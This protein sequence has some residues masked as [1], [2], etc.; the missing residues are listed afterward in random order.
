MEEEETTPETILFEFNGNR[1]WIPSDLYFQ[2]IAD[3]AFLN[4]FT[5]E[6]ILEKVTPYLENLEP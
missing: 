1:Y 4:T 2:L 5:E 3:A 6:Q